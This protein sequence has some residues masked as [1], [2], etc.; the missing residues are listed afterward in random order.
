VIKAVFFDIGETILDRTAE[1]QGW[2]RFL[3]V[4]AHTFSAVFGA[5]V[6]RGGGVR[7]AVAVFRPDEPLGELRRQAN[8]AGFL[9]DVAESDLYPDARACLLE[10][11]ESGLYVGIVGNQPRVV[12][13]QLREMQLA[14]DVIAVSADWQLDKPDARFF[15]ECVRLAGCAPDELVYVGDQLGNDVVAARASGVQSVRVLTGPW[16]Y[17]VRDAEL[18]AQC[19]AVIGSLAELPEMLRRSGVLG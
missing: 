8:A 15:L 10:L 2:A 17:I 6:E 5:V 9:P 13:A 18:E 1:Y 3:D 7:E 14:A 4:P 11:H 16:G 12:G 19:L